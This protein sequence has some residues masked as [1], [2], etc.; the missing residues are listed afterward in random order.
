MISRKTIDKY[1]IKNQDYLKNKIRFFH[2]DLWSFNSRDL[3]FVIDLKIA[4]NSV[5]GWAYGAWL[6]GYYPVVYGVSFFNIGRFE[7]LRKFFGFH[8]APCLIINA[9]A[10]GYKNYGWEHSFMNFEDEKLMTSIGFK[11]IYVKNIQNYD[12]RSTKQLFEKYLDYNSENKNIY[13]KLY[14]D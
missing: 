9:G 10:Y 14:K 12:I 2:N 7:Q 1:L 4:E 3:D 11:V 8:K 13:I 6:T 5:W